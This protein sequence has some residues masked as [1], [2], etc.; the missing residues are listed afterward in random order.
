[1]SIPGLRH[2]LHLHFIVILLGFTAVLGKLISLDALSLVWIRTFFAALGLIVF[3]SWK[4]HTLKTSLHDAFAFLG[5][6]VVVAAHW[7]SFFHA[8]KVSNVSVTLG[9]FASVALF[10]SILEPL[11]QKRKIQGLEVIIG[12]FCIGG[13]YLIFRFET[14]YMTGML[15]ALLSALLNAVFAVLNKAVSHKA[16]PSVISFYEM[17]GGFLS[18][19]IFLAL[20]Y[21]GAAPS[22]PSGIADWA[23]ILI[24]AIICTSYAFSA[25]VDL[26]KVLSAYY[27]M[28]AINLEPV[29]GIILAFLIFG[30][31][32]FMS[33]GFYFGTAIVMVC[34]FCYPFLHKKLSSGPK[35]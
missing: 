14:H 25:I 15:Y 31:S 18:L 1:M 13:L 34:V 3:L 2:H 16:R 32:E 9:C 20:G 22:L 26:L 28:L 8:I 23:Y 5:I 24:L 27:V 30:Q 17:A 7:V 4:K 29:Y 12:L 21:G 19:S 11:F 35:Y 33:T 6:G 10:T